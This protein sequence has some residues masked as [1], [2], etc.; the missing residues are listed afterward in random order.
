[1]AKAG[2]IASVCALGLLATPVMAATG[3]QSTVGDSPTNTPAT[4]TGA[5]ASGMQNGSPSAPGSTTLNSSPYGATTQNGASTQNGSVT[6]NAAT[7]SAAGSNMSGTNGMNT[8]R[9][10]SDNAARN[11]MA[12]GSMSGPNGT[13]GA[14]NQ[15]GATG[16]DSTDSRAGMARSDTARHANNGT[17]S[18][19]SSGM[20]SAQDNVADQL[21]GQ[22]LQAAEQGHAY[23]A[24]AANMGSGMSAPPPAAGQASPG[25]GSR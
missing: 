15:S 13:A 22:S 5:G 7:Q 21:N 2:L 18:G 20:A 1:M 3:M 8:N 4:G 25:G 10:G 24:G 9:A 6:Q 12:A 17:H 19:R 14:S 23:D 11:D 16:S